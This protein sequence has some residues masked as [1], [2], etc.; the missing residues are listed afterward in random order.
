[1]RRSTSTGSVPARAVF[2][3]DVLGKKGSDTGMWRH[4]ERPTWRKPR[5][6]SQAPFSPPSL[7]PARNTPGSASGFVPDWPGRKMADAFS[8]PETG[9]WIEQVTLPR[10]LSLTT[11]DAST[12]NSPS[13]SWLWDSERDSSF[14]PAMSLHCTLGLG[15]QPPEEHRTWIPL[16]SGPIMR[17]WGAEPKPEERRHVPEACSP[18]WSGVPEAEGL[19]AVH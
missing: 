18:W 15:N 3:G 9:F 13:P 14:P 7:L 12:W 16:S 8:W 10:E 19:I 1:M 2:H 4:S 17:T 5:P 11:R 6:L